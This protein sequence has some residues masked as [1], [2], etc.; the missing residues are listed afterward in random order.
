MRLPPMLCSILDTLS[1]PM[2]YRV[3][4]TVYSFVWGVFTIWFLKVLTRLWELLGM[5]TEANRCFQKISISHCRAGW[6][7]V[8]G[9]KL[10]TGV[11][12]SMKTKRASHRGISEFRFPSLILPYLVRFYCA[13][14]RDRTWVTREMYTYLQCQH[15][16]PA[17]N[18][19]SA[20]S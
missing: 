5:Q 10:S 4:L 17:L 13:N 14:T 9:R 7:S 20:R 8:W 15:S 2:R 16:I 12:L 6:G 11:Y 19:W 18:V 3:I 1:R